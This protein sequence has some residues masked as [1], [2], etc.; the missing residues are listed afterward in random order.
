MKKTFAAAAVAV[1]ALASV[2]AFAQAINFTDIDANADGFLSFTEVT[3]ID[4]YVTPE[5]F[6]AADMDT[7]GFLNEAEFIEL[8]E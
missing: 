3:N 7:D 5:V 8:V 2:S 1:T 6:D 4:P